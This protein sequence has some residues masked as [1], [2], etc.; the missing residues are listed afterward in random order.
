MLHNVHDMTAALHELTGEGYP[1]HPDDLA[2]LS[3]YA[4]HNIKRFG[5]YLLPPPDHTPGP[6]NGDL[7]LNPTGAP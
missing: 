6:F 5:D 2:T 3:P 7:Y 1:V 4:T